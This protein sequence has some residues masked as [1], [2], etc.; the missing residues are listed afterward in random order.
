M[1]YKGKKKPKTLTP[2]VYTVLSTC[3]LSLIEW[4]CKLVSADNFWFIFL[5]MGHCYVSSK[6]IEESTQ[7][8]PELSNISKTNSLTSLYMSSEGKRSTVGVKEFGT[9]GSSVL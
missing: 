7:K 9:R 8:C 5:R 4:I 2:S 1:F 6:N 3:F